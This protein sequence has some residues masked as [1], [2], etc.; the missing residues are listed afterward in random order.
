V[1]R[2]VTAPPSRPGITGYMCE[3]ET[4]T[5]LTAFIDENKLAF[6]IVVRGAGRVSASLSTDC[7]TRHSFVNGTAPEPPRW[8]H[9]S[10]PPAAPASSGPSSVFDHSSNPP[11]PPSSDEALGTGR[12]TFPSS[13]SLRRI[14]TQRTRTQSPCSP[15]GSRTTTQPSGRPCCPLLVISDPEP[16][17]S[18]RSLWRIPE[19]LPTDLGSGY[20]RRAQVLTGS[21]WSQL[22]PDKQ[23]LLPDIVPPPPPAPWPH[24]CKVQRASDHACNRRAAPRPRAPHGACCMLHP[25]PT[26]SLQVITRGCKKIAEASVVEG[27]TAITPYPTLIH[28][29]NPCGWPPM[30]VES[31]RTV[32][33]GGTGVRDLDDALEDYWDKLLW[34]VCGRC[35]AGRGHASSSTTLDHS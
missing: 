9:R 33:A 30:P 16:R 13:R 18:Y 20:N 25:R 5:E 7:D 6:P 29:R 3:D 1:R 31:D 26:P 4:F 10:R 27:G 14:R 15:A 12:V 17:S 21:L 32:Q 8:L 34:P 24:I 28:I 19:K 2:E 35:A 22:K 23:F 11:P